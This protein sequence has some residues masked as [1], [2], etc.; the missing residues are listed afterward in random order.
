MDSVYA[1]LV[2]LI[3][4]NFGIPED[5]VTPDTTF[6]DLEFDSLALLELSVVVQHEFGLK[7]EEGA[8]DATDTLARAAELI[9]IT[10]IKA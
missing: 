7:I 2:S 10:G 3:T 4:S 6:D 8:L 5:Q 1:R 9:D